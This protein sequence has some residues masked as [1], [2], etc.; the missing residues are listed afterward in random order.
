MIRFYCLEYHVLTNFMITKNIETIGL[1]KPYL[2]IKIGFRTSKLGFAKSR[3][4]G[5]RNGEKAESTNDLWRMSILNCF[6]TQP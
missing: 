1:F 4:S 3:E 6:A 5:A 2:K